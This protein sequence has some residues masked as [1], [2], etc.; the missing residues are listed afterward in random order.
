M[1]NKIFEIGEQNLVFLFS[2][3][4]VKNIDFA[5]ISLECIIN[6]TKFD[7]SLYEDKHTYYFFHIQSLL[8]ACGNI[9]NIFYN[10]GGFRGRQDTE[11]CCMM[12]ETFGINKRCFPLIFQKE[13]RN[14]NEHFDERLEGFKGNVGDYNLLEKSVPENVRKIIRNNPHLR[15]LDMDYGVYY[16]FNRQLKPIEYDLKVLRGELIEMK[17]AMINNPIYDSEWAESI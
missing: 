9:T 5:L 14:T 10:F 6:R 15:T 7:E 17:S 4:A 8:T 3:Q 12:R 2:Q 1:F 13:V 11:R 16:T